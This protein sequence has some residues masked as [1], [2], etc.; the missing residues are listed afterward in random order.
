MLSRT[1]V[2]P[3]F[4]HVITDCRKLAQQGLGGLKWQLFIPNHENQQGCIMA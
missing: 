2:T 3:G 4:S 1:G